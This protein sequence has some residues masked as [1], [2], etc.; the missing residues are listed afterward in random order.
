MNTSVS[1]GFWLL[2]TPLLIIVISISVLPAYGAGLWSPVGGRQAGLNHCSVALSDFWSIQNNQ[3]GMALIKKFSAGIAYENRFLIPH[4]GTGN[5][6]VIYPMKFGNMGLSIGYFGYSLYHQMKIG[7][8]YAR[9]FGPR[10]RI[11]V[12]LDYLQTALGNGYGSRNNITFALGIQSDI[13][14][15][16]TLGVYVFNPV[17]VKLADYANEKIPAIFRFGLAYHF[18]GKLLATVEA[19]K[20]TAY[21]P[22]VLRGG[23]E[24]AF[25]KQFFFRVGFGTSGDVLSFGF[26]WHKKHIRFDIGTS[27]HQSLGFSPQSSVVFTF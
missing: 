10:L 16:L 26:G 8:A 23:V 6:A 25:K 27:M 15:Q 19:E 22:I 2:K 14:K 9:A 13:T 20:N 21:Q 11:G 17:P 12:Q 7:L 18:S 4:T 3:A 1:N 5:V 24:Y